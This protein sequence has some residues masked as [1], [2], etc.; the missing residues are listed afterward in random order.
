[1]EERLRREIFK[2]PLRTVRM[3]TPFALYAIIEQV[4]YKII[5]QDGEYCTFQ[6]LT[7][8]EFEAFRQWQMKR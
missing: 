8:A 4:P 3:K 6:E 7:S 2:P 1:M 5:E